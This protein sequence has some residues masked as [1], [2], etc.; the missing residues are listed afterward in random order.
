MKN[1]GK[2]IAE[3]MPWLLFARVCGRYLYFIF[4]RLQSRPGVTRCIA[5]G[6]SR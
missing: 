3:Y 2:R 4:L 1:Y 6:F 5:G